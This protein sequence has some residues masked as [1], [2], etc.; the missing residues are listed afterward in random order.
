M[1]DYQ[2][3]ARAIEFIN[4]N[5][6]TQPTLEEIAAHLHM[7]S[8]HFQRLFTRWAGI[9]PK[10]FLQQATLNQ[11]RE[12]LGR[13]MSTLATSYELGLS[14]TARLH[15]HFV[16]LAA[17]TPGEYKSGG[18]GLCIAYGLHESPFGKVFIAT[19][20]RGI[21]QLSFIDDDGRTAIKDLRHSWP[22]ADIH[23]SANATKPCIRQIFSNDTREKEPLSVYIKGTNFQFS[24]WR[25][26]LKIPAGYVTSYGQIADMVGNTR[27]ARA[28]GQAVGANPVAW[29]IPCHRVIRASGALGDYRWGKTRKQILLACEGADAGPS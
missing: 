16:S 25:A 4:Q 20:Y 26:L 23:A 2:R 10:R 6:N 18:D 21:C 9:S 8:S 19:T 27:A 22:N 29:L 17:V 3:I 15:D 5:V 7:S 11:A 24:V 1:N 28:V 12:L 13:S 14:S